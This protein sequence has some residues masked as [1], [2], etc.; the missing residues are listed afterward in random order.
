[1]LRS[2]W[3]IQNEL[4]D[5]FIAFLSIALF[6]L[7]FLSYCFCLGVFLFW[8][9]YVCFLFLASVFSEIAQMSSN[10][11]VCGGCGQDL[12]RVGGRQKHSQNILNEK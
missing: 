5:I 1:M 2:S 9:S 3:S 10:K 6:G 7:F 8:G 4:N 12:G 11:A